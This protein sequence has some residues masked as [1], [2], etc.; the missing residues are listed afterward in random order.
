MSLILY[1]IQYDNESL[2]YD[3]II[4][5]KISK[6]LINIIKTKK[7]NIIFLKDQVLQIQ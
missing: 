1:I 6:V 4:L 7:N 5:L 3:G 2:N